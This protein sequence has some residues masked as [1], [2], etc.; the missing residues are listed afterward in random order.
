[1]NWDPERKLGKERGISFHTDA[2]TYA[3]VTVGLPPK[4]LRLAFIWR[5][6]VA[7]HRDIELIC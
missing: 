6:W 3:I 4:F 2:G 7:S 5:G 1:M